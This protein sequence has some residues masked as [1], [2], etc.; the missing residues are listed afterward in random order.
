MLCLNASIRH[1]GPS[2]QRLLQAVE[3]ARALTTLVLAAWQVGRLLAVHLIEAVLAARA[4]RPPGP[5]APGVAWSC[6]AR[7]LP[8]GRC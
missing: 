3:E 6:A 8:R 7:A 4:S 5:P 2:V 1:Q